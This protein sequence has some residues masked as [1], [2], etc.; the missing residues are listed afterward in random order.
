MRLLCAAAI[1]R[2]SDGR[3]LL[4]KIRSKG[5]PVKY[6]LISPEREL[7]YLTGGLKRLM[8]RYGPFR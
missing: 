1:P 5:R 3:R 4:G 2:D 8:L 7:M 6:I